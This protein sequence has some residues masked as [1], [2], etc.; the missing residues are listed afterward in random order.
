M[1]IYAN[2]TEKCHFAGG[3]CSYSY[4]ETVHGGYWVGG[5]PRWLFKGHLPMPIVNKNIAMVTG[6]LPGL[7]GESDVQSVLESK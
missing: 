1:A 6:I 7:Q 4:E 5:M 2:K 3:Y